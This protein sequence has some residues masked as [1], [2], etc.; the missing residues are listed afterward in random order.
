MTAKRYVSTVRRDTQGT[1]RTNGGMNS[2][3]A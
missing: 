1:A 2:A 3:W